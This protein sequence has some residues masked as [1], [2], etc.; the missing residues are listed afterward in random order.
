MQRKLNDLICRTDKLN[1]KKAKEHWKAKGL[2]FSRLFYRPDVDRKIAYYN[3]EKQNHPIDDIIDRDLIVI[4]RK[5][6]K[7]KSKRSVKL[8]IK[9]TDRTTGAMLSGFIAKKRGHKGL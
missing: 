5:V 6:I 9:N 4:A 2:D 7:D 3:C 1:A 8:G